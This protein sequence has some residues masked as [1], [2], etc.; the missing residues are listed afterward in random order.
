MF[1]LHNPVKRVKVIKPPKHD[2]TFKVKRSKAI[3]SQS[4]RENY[5]DQDDFLQP[6]QHV[7][8]WTKLSGIR[9]NM[10]MN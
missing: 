2:K 4:R 9:T 10:S 8:R 7:S 3:H 5:V 6:E 1:K